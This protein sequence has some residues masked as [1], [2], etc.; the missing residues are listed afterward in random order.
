MIWLMQDKYTPTNNNG[1]YTER[2]YDYADDS[3]VV[4]DRSIQSISSPKSQDQSSEV[5]NM[6]LLMVGCSH[7]VS[8]YKKYTL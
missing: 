6:P 1:R 5:L 7:L 4:T 8:A 2:G 3:Q